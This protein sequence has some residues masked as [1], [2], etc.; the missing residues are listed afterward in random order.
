VKNALNFRLDVLINTLI[1]RYINVAKFLTCIEN[2]KFLPCLKY[3]RANLVQ[4]ILFEGGGKEFKTF[5]KAQV[6]NIY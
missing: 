3:L 4:Y 1:I 6:Q 5:K 2:A